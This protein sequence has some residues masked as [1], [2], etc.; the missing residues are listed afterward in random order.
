[1]F[2]PESACSRLGK[3]NFIL[4]WITSVDSEIA[5]IDF[6]GVECWKLR[7]NESKEKQTNPVHHIPPAASPTMRCRDISWMQSHS[8]IFRIA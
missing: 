4:G 7:E 1:M 3:R 2:R 8:T 6:L 5:I